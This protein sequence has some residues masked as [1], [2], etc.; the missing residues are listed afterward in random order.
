MNLLAERSLMNAYNSNNAVVN[1]KIV[2]QA[3]HDALGDEFEVKPWW[4]NS[5]V[6]VGG[7]VSALGIVLVIG[8]WWGTYHL[9]GIQPE[10][11][12]ASAVESNVESNAT[13]TLSINN[14][15][16]LVNTNTNENTNIKHEYKY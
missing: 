3:A 2:L 6:K 9:H 8:I 11:S 15:A 10:R 5:F 16:T 7:L 14:N 1:R 4:Q 13:Q 12:L